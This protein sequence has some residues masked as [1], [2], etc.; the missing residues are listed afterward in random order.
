MHKTITLRYR[1]FLCIFYWKENGI[2]AFRTKV[3]AVPQFEQRT[4][5]FMRCA[6]CFLH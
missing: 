1:Y 2:C 5:S 6:N 3:I 4:K